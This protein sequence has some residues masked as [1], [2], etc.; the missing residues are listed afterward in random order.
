M[1]YFPLTKCLN[2]LCEI[3][4][5]TNF[6][7]YIYI[8]IYVYIYVLPKLLF[9]SIV[10]TRYSELSRDKISLKI[11]HQEH[12]KYLDTSMLITNECD[13]IDKDKLLTFIVLFLIP[14]NHT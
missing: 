1:S 9:I 12:F 2:I 10:S 5:V 4:I 7:T 3:D 8:Y 11:F 13:D 14:F 6:S